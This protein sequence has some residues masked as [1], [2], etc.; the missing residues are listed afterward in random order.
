MWTQQILGVDSY[1]VIQ[2]F[3]VYSILGWCVESIYM[4]IC[5]QKLTNRG[6]VKGPICPIYG[7][8]ALGVYFLLRPVSEDYILLYFCGAVAATAFE[9]LVGKGMHVLFGEIWWDYNEKP[10][11]Y[12]GIVCLEST[13]AWGFYTLIMFGFLQ[14]IVENIV[15]SYSYQKGVFMGTVLIILFS[16]DLG[17]SLYKAKKDELP[18]TAR[19]IKEVIISKLYL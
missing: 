8:G 3:F 5:N 1:H 11:N 12:K 2:W 4:S 14:K 17:H 18:Y 6:F 13:I 10:F 16:A 9:F 15:N 7:F 19:D